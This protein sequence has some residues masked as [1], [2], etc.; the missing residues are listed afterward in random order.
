MRT[1]VHN[2]ALQG[3]KARAEDY[4]VHTFQVSTKAAA[5]PLCAPYQGKIL[6]WRAGDRGTVHDLYG[7][8]YEYTSIYDTSYGEPAGLFGI[9]CGHFPNTFVDG[10][11]IP[12]YKPLDEEGEKRNAE[13]YR[14]SQEQRR[15]ERDVR[16]AKTE[17][18]A[19]DAAGDKEAFEQTAVKVK[20]ATK[21]Y[22][23]FCSS[24]ELTERLD[25]VQVNGYN[26]SVSG[27][28]T[29]VARRQALTRNIDLDDLHDVTSGTGML[30]SVSDAIGSKLKELEQSGGFMI[31]YVSGSIQS[32]EKGT[33][34]FQIEPKFY[35]RGT[36]LIQLNINTEYLS[37]KTIADIDT[38]F[39]NS[40]G[41]FANSLEEALI[42]ESGHAKQ[43][44]GKTYNEIEKMYKELDG[45]G[46]PG[47]S[48]TA[49]FDGAE[50]LA[51]IEILRSKGIAL[52]EEQQAL[53]NTYMR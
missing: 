7:N 31:N 32:A 45:K 33:A 19:Y 2:T 51:D 15:L 11:S 48:D 18:L 8:A 22:K 43:I 35:G 40:N 21:D 34:V 37:G 23:A 25:R 38:A 39:K 28:A 4:D 42:H 14:I 10:Y 1:T 16:K 46:L 30:D 5:R 12:R 44:S 36:A 27:K 41:T 52:T 13:E 50:A 47:L 53:Y 26:R 24:N 17:A 6:S 29:W 49:R 3:Q 9:N 20:Q